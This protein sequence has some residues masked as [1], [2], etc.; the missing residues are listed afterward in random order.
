MFQKRQ[1]SQIDNLRKIRQNYEK[2]VDS[3][4]KQFNVIC[5]TPNDIITKDNLDD[6]DKEQDRFMNCHF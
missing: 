5:G 3:H 2:S 6:N 1:L 4:K